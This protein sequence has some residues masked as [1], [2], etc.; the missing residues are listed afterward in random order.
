MSPSPTISRKRTIETSQQEQ[1]NTRS[2][3]EESSYISS[4]N[5]K[6][7]RPT[8]SQS[9][10]RHENHRHIRQYPK[11]LEIFIPSNKTENEREVI[12]S[13]HYE[14]EKR[15][16]S[17][18][19]NAKQHR[20]HEIEIAEEYLRR[21]DDLTDEY[22]KLAQQK[23]S[24][25]NQKKSNTYETIETTYQR[26]L[27]EN[28]LPKYFKPIM[29]TDITLS[30]D[31]LSAMEYRLQR[32]ERLKPIRIHSST[33]SIPGE[34]SFKYVQTERTPVEVLVP[35]PQI[36]TTRGEHSSTVVRDSRQS[37]RK[38]T[39]NVHQQPRRRT[40]E[41]QHELRI[42]EK[43]IAYGQIRPVEF[44]I[45]KPIETLPTEHS[46]T[47]VV[48]SKKGGRFHTLDISE[49]L[50]RQRTL[51][52]EH[53]LRVISEPIRSNFY[54]KPVE[55]LFPKP[56]YSTQS[57]HHSSTIVKQN[58][59]PKSSLFLD[60]IQTILKGEHELRLID[61]PIQS[62]TMNSVELIVPK[63]VTDTAE[64]Q[65]TIITE[66]QPQRRVLEITGSGKQML[67]EHERK[68]FH[69]TVRVEEEIEVKLPKQKFEQSEHSAT[70]IKHSRGKGPIIE[71]DTRQQ[72]IQGEHD[73]KIFEESIQT[74]SDTMQLVI[75][76]PRIPAEHTTTLI[77]E[78]RGKSQIFAIDRTKPIAGR[79]KFLIIFLFFNHLFS[80]GEY[81]TKYYNRPVESYGEMEVIFPKQR[82]VIGSQEG[83]HMSTLVKQIHSKQTIYDDRLYEIPGEHSLTVVDS[84]NEKINKEVE[85]IVP[86]PSRKQFSD[87][88]QTSSDYDERFMSSTYEEEE[89][90]EMSGE[91][92]TTY[93]KQARAKYEPIELVVD[94]P[95]IQPSI[96][97][98]IADIPPPTQITSIKPTTIHF[99]EDSSSKLDMQLS[100]ESLYE[101]Y[102]EMEIVLEKP[103][104]RD[105][106]T[107]LIANIQPGLEL[108]TIQA[109]QQIPKTLEKSSS[110]LTMQ[111]ER[112]TEEELVE[113]RI[114]KPYI[115]DSSSTLLANI[116]PELGIQGRLKATPYIPQPIEESSS[117]LTMELN[118]HQEITPFELIIPRI[119]KESSTSTVLAQI[120]PAIAGLRAKIDIPKLEKSTSSF[121]F[122]HKKSFDQEVELI[123]P[124][125]KHI[126]TSTSTMLADVQAKL[127]TKDI[128]STEIQ[129]EISTSTFY[130]DETI[131]NV[132][133]QPVE[134][135]MKQPIIADSST[136]LFANVKP[137]L[138]TKQV[139]FLGNRYQSIQESSSEILFETKTE[140][141][142]PSEVELIL[143]RPHIQESTSVML[144]NVRPTLDTSQTHI[145]IPPPYQSPI[146]SSSEIIFEQDKIETTPVELHLHR[147]TSSHTLLAKLDDT[148]KKNKEMY[149]LGTG[150]QQQQ[151]QYGT[152]TIHADLNKPVQ[153]IFNI[154][155]DNT[156]TTTRQYRRMLP[157]G[158]D[159]SSTLI[160]GK[161]QRILN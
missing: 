117:A 64:H 15:P 113:L 77:K 11:T 132:I 74:K 58:R 47:F 141:I 83:E 127:E 24:F 84:S 75:P 39:T 89:E 79:I 42:I 142:Q 49:T 152:S 73:M 54:N 146:K 17:S 157:G 85:F 150:N 154:D 72:I 7:Y 110:T 108:K 40:I 120:S 138:D 106:S 97:R 122:E 21:L 68:Y 20:Q 161:S 34:T 115:Q 153:L 87:Y 156:S 103:L 109:T 62:G 70:V 18:S 44:T 27:S 12:R 30:E 48:K 101:Q 10:T 16:R 123:M 37:T 160:T 43:P 111:R 19:E 80:L 3:K 69:D 105:S 145:V 136:T 155:E 81:E 51:S 31:E 76:K 52:G 125:P 104:I 94:R 139:Q 126:E 130:F 159:N 129:P 59:A 137:T 33:N 93:L 55:L 63:S 78:Q 56:T 91:H 38:I 66:T 46:S 1:F 4:N 13:Y 61:Q 22:E 50:S 119:D 140:H 32:K 112:Q 151:Q 29:T 92:T 118:T 23:K 88:Y 28:F 133:P 90:E 128:R 149:I 134:I 102:D 131:Q 99:T 135:R 36:I 116:Q 53:E 14:V 35:K 57:S 6:R 9:L 121:L 26:S 2:V 158:V 147:Q 148:R 96:S 143:P 65:T 5:H 25:H 41:G 124:K 144:A 67:S 100:N 45:P 8:Q 114:R 95:R 71:I 86:K 107:T 98:L 82:P 60:N